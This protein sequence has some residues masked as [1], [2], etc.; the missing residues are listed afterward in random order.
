M[1]V[2]PGRRAQIKLLVGDLIMV[3]VLVGALL[4]DGIACPDL[5]LS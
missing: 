1:A 4:S 3:A 2:G 5:G